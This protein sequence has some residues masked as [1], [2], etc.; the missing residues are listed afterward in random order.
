MRRW[1]D[2]AVG[3]LWG[4]LFTGLVVTVSGFIVLTVAKK[5]DA[6]SKIGGMLP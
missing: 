1:I 6:L 3:F 2:R 4:V 5:A